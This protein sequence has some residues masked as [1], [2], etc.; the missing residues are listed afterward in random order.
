MSYTVTADSNTFSIQP[1]PVV[2]LTSPNS[3]SFAHNANIN[4]TWSKTDYTGNVDLFYTTSTTFSTSNPISTNQSGTSYT[5]DVPTS[6]SGTSIYLWVRVYNN[7]T[8]KDRSNSSISIT[9]ATLNVTLSDSLSFAD[10][11][12][13]TE[14]IWRTLH[15]VAIT[16]SISFSE[17]FTRN[18]TFDV[19]LTDSM[20]LADSWTK[21]ESVW[22]RYI[23]VVLSDSLSL[24][25]SWSKTESIWRNFFNVAL[26]DSLGFTDTA[27]TSTRTWKYNVPINESLGMSDAT[28]ITQRDWIHFRSMLDTLTPTD[29]WSKFERD[30]IHFRTFVDSIPVS[31]SHTT[32]QKKWI[33]F[34]DFSD[35]LSMSDF[36]TEA[37]G[38]LALD[39]LLLTDSWIT[40]VSKQSNVYQLDSSNS[41]ESVQSLYRT[42]WIAPID[43]DRNVVLR[44]INIDY[45]SP[46]NL[47]VKIFSNEDTVNAVSTKTIPSSVTPTHES[48]RLSTRVKYFQV[49]IETPLSSLDNVRIERIEIEVDE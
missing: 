31:D 48:I 28:T 35:S 7:S 44:R 4:I 6:L 25:D 30:W 2:V 21:T 22:R 37:I 38:V 39:N 40:S 9:V 47:T 29:T 18:S 17:T 10:N 16:D 43:L 27:S 33:L 23:D 12:T 3:G 15:N 26:T 8:F 42:G 5:W 46:V 20:G 32:S 36:Q 1:E 13:K 49:Q 24:S 14:S 45:T 11:W 19:Q 34:V 41:T